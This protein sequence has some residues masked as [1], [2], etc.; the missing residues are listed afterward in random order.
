MEGTGETGGTWRAH[1]EARWI[2]WLAALST[3]GGRALRRNTPIFCTPRLRTATHHCAN[4]MGTPATSC[5]SRSTISSR[6]TL[7]SP[8]GRSTAGNP[9]LASCAALGVGEGLDALPRCLSVLGDRW[10][11]CPGGV[12][13]ELLVLLLFTFPFLALLRLS[14]LPEAWP[15]RV[16][17]ECTDAVCRCG[18][19]VSATAALLPRAPGAPLVCRALGRVVLRSTAVVCG[20]ELPPRGLPARLRTETG[21]VGC[22]ELALDEVVDCAELALEV[23]VADLLVAVAARDVEVAAASVRGL[24]LDAPLDFR[25]RRPVNPRSLDCLRLLGFRGGVRLSALS[26]PLL[27]PAGLGCAEPAALAC[28]TAEDADTETR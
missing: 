25:G 3:T 23:A 21:E 12:L 16:E 20:G 14:A 4:A 7:K 5:S 19:L 27:A 15:G 6:G 24:A 26:A 1:G 18:V 2:P 22:I 9:A 17:V 28:S 11:R 10:L 13:E 8:A